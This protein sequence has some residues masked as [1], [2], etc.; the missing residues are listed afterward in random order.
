MTLKIISA[1]QVE[2]EGEVTQVSLPGLMGRFQVLRG[3]AAMIA[4]L[5]AGEATYTLQDDGT[6]VSLDIA[7]GV[8]DVKNDVVSVCLY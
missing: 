8:A 7:G 1:E 6:T 5:Q 2:F 4:A 3:H